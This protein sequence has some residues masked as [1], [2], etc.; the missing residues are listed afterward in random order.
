MSAQILWTMWSKITSLILRHRVANIVVVAIMTLFM[1]YEATKMEMSYELAKSL[2]ETDSTM[3]AYNRFLDRYGHDGAMIFVAVKDSNMFA[4]EHFNA[5]YELCDTIDHM[6]GVNNVLSIANL[7]DIRI[8]LANSLDQKDWKYDIGRLADTMPQTQA[9]VDSL[10]KVI[11]SLEFYEGILFNSKE[12]VWIMLITL[13]NDFINSQKRETLSF[14]IEDMV[15]SFSEKFDVETHVSGMPYI[16]TK[17]ATVVKHELLVFT[18]MALFM[19]VCILM[20]FFKSWRN[21]L[22]IITIVMI[23]VI[24]LFGLASLLGFKITIFMSVLPPIL[25]IIGVENSIF[26]LNKYHAEYQKTH[27]KVKAL[28]SVIRRIGS[29]NLLTNATTAAG[30]ASFVITQNKT[31]VEF[32]ILASVSIFMAYLLS[33]FLIPIFFSYLSVP[34]EKDFA[35]LDNK[36]IGSILNFVVKVAFEHR[37][38]VYVILSVLVVAG[39]IG[40]SKLKT[41]GR[42]VDDISKS[43][44]IYQDLAFF[45][46][47]LN[48]IV[49]LEISIETKGDRNGKVSNTRR[50]ATIVKIDQLSD[51]IVNQ[52]PQ[53]SKPLSV[54]EVVKFANS[55]VVNVPSGMDAARLGTYSVPDVMTLR[56]IMDAVAKN[57]KADSLNL[58]R[59][60]N[61]F[62]DSNFISTR[63]SVRMLNLTTPEV[64]EVQQSLEPKIESIFPSDRYDVEVTGSCIVNN[65]GTKYLTTSLLYSLLLAFVIIAFLMA[66]TFTSF[67]M[68]LV[69]MIPNFIPQLLT[70]GLMGFLGI[71]IKMS[72]ILIFSIALGISVDNTIHFLARYRLQL[73]MNNMSVGRSVKGAI[74]ETGYSMVS[75]ATVLLCGF[76]MFCFSSFQGTQVVGCLVPFTLFMALCSNLFVLPCILL[77]FN[78][79]LLGDSIDNSFFDLSQTAEEKKEIEQVIKDTIST[80]D[81]HEGNQ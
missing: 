1:G 48:G 54:A 61:S 5:W 71:P 73:R 21:V 27:N 36:R 4:L 43:D 78:K 81:N 51:T 13:D 74:I 46:K 7:F 11:R 29:A 62:V 37:A 72:T 66:L 55:R 17:I 24:F 64:D 18:L 22:P 60:I 59:I 26:L 57:K 14:A 23:S 16:R 10:E 38:A 80:P 76:L 9:E 41:M 68:V 52:Y 6:E 30:F 63:V 2:S 45:E 31:L 49:P 53:L 3:M 25:I 65:E 50:A 34:S 35:R 70:A 75:S 28:S 39:G 47:N 15:N 8:D 56:K 40:L 32:G 44:Q 42:M 77:T 58:P 19:S 67:K 79:K 69:S 12:D 33:L 20:L